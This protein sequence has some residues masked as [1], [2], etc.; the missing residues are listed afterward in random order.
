MAPSYTPNKIPGMALPS[1]LLKYE[2]PQ[3]LQ[4]IMQAQALQRA[5]QLQTQQA[6]IATQQKQQAFDQE[7]TMREALQAEFSSQDDPDLAKGLEVAKRLAFQ[8]GDLD[9]ALQVEKVQNQRKDLTPYS[10][11]Q[12]NAIALQLG[13]E[14]PPSQEGYTKEF[15]RD[16][17][18]SKR[19]DFGM[20]KWND[21]S[22]FGSPEW[23]LAEGARGD[24]KLD[25]EFKKAEGTNLT[26]NG[27]IDE[28]DSSVAMT[29]TSVDPSTPEFQRQKQLIALLATEMKNMRNFG[30][31][32][33]ALEARLNQG[34][35]PQLFADPNVPLTEALYAAGLGRDP[36]TA[37]AELKRQLNFAF[38][39]DAY[40]RNYK[41]RGTQGGMA[42]PTLNPSSGGSAIDAAVQRGT[43]SQGSNNERSQWIQKRAA[44]IKAQ[45]MAQ[46]G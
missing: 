32:F 9:T 26:L 6:E 5:Q 16:L 45:R 18:S 23:E 19:L 12:A 30:A 2:E 3:Q 44:E 36:R 37:I 38:E 7:N 4:D 14:L 33:T 34:S 8:T 11:D 27:L 10:Q 40:V 28:L 31:N 24:P 35:L 43:Q 29:G 25:R 1:S 20:D 39:N 17:I 46:G 15:V 22:Q 42:K 21:Q 41:R 13:V